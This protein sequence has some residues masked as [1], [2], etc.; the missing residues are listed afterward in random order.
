MA[1]MCRFTDWRT[2][3][4]IYVNAAAV[5]TIKSTAK[6]GTEITFIDEAMLTVREPVDEVARVLYAAN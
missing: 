5:R 2:R 6:G 1:Q 3:K 4:D